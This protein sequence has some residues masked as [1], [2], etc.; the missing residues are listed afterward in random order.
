MCC[1]KNIYFIFYVSF[2]KLF[3]RRFDLTRQSINHLWKSTS[4]CTIFIEKLRC[5]S[6]SRLLTFVFI[7][8]VRPQYLNLVFCLFTIEDKVIWYTTLLYVCICC[9]T[10]HSF[11]VVQYHTNNTVKPPNTA[12]RGNGS[13]TVVLEKWW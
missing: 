12:T 5:T 9:K 4:G 7:N 11:L 10:S 2:R 6:L 13:K 8:A 1:N 3:L